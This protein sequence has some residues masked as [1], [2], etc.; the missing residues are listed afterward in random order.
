MLT[1]STCNCSLYSLSLPLTVWSTS[2]IRP[3][4]SL[5]SWSLAMTFSRFLS[6]LTTLPVLLR[7]KSSFC[8]SRLIFEIALSFSILPKCSNSPSHGVKWLQ[9]L[10]FVL[11]SA[12]LQFPAHYS[13]FFLYHP[14]LQK[15][16]CWS[17]K[18]WNK[19]RS[20]LHFSWLSWFSLTSPFSEDTLTHVSLVINS[21][22]PFCVSSLAAPNLM[23]SFLTFVSN[24]SRIRLYL[25]QTLL[26]VTSK[27]KFL[28]WFN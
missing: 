17:C 26:L 8:L 11:F 7:L 12:C 27:L 22:S 14:F 13:Y 15:Y 21:T 9:I 19:S 16:S 2:K 18:T 28:F 20:C 10:F 6:Y 5:S 4:S 24:R 1:L 3:H 25:L 23:P